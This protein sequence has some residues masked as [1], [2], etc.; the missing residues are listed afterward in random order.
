MADRE[1]L[2]CIDS[3]VRE[4]VDKAIERFQKAAAAA[5]NDRAPDTVKELYDASD[6][7]MRA[8]GRVLVD[9]TRRRT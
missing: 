1:R 8:L 6:E 9:I 5:E 2:G 7:L 3:S 4:R